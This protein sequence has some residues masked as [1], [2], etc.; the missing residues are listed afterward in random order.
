LLL[1]REQSLLGVPFLA[2]ELKIAQLSAVLQ[3]IDRCELV[4]KEEDEA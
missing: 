2:L 4:P 3:W 1:Q